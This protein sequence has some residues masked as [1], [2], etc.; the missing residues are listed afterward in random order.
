ML[1]EAVGEVETSP[2]KV[3]YKR[4]SYKQHY[5]NQSKPSPSGRRCHVVTDEGA[6][7]N[8]LLPFFIMSLRGT[9]LRSLFRKWCDLPIVHARVPWQSPERVHF[10]QGYI[11]QR[12]NS[13]NNL[14]PF[15][16]A[17]IY[18]IPPQRRY[19][20]HPPL[21]VKGTLLVVWIK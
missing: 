1:S 11:V 20:D 13:R 9:V 6:Y 14:L 5:R 17:E 2:G 15:S 7:A 3:P 10:E 19:P 4:P 8:T 12:R 21:M 18:K 16:I